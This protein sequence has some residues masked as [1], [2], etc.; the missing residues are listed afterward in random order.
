MKQKKLGEGIQI[1][2]EL[3]IPSI[4]LVLCSF[5]KTIS[6]SLMDTGSI[7]FYLSKFGITGIEY[8]IAL[9]GLALVLIYPIELALKNKSPASLSF[10]VITISLLSLI[11]SITCKFYPEHSFFSK[12]FVIWRECCRMTAEAAFMVIS[13][14][15]GLFSKKINTLI[16]LLMINSLGYLASAFF[17]YIG[18]KINPLNWIIFSSFFMFLAGSLSLIIV[19]NGSAPFSQKLSFSKTDLKRSGIDSKQRRFFLS[20]FSTTFLLYVTIALFDFNFFESLVVITSQNSEQITILFSFLY[21]LVALSNFIILVFTLQKKLGSFPVLYALPISLIIACITGWIIYVNPHLL[22][23]NKTT[24]ILFGTSLVARAVFVLMSHIHKENIF[25]VLPWAV[26]ERSFFRSTIERKMIVEPLGLMLA[27]IFIIFSIKYGDFHFNLLTALTSSAFVLILSL[28]ILR[29]QYNKLVFLNIKNRLWRGGRM[30]ITGHRIRNLI[31]QMLCSDNANDTIYALRILEDALHPCLFQ[32]YFKSLFHPSPEVRLFALE[33]L[34]NLKCK[35]A[36]NQIKYCLKTEYDTAV[37]SAALKA[38]CVLGSPSD[39]IE[40]IKYI[41]DPSLCEGALT[42]LLAVGLEGSFAAIDKVSSMVNYGDSTAQ[43]QAA[44]ILGESGKLAFFQPLSKLLNSS[45]LNVCYQA[46]MAAG[47]LKSPELLPDIINIFRYPQLREEGLST[48]L[49]YQNLALPTFKQIW[50]SPDYPHQFKSMLAK[51][52]HKINTPEC[53]DLL[54]SEINHDD[55]RIRFNILKSLVLM[56]YKAIGNKNISFARL[57]LYDEIEWATNLLSSIDQLNRNSDEKSRNSIQILISA[58]KSEIEYSKERIM[59]LLAILEPTPDILHLLSHYNSSNEYRKVEQIHIVDKILS[60][61]L[62]KIC[63]PFFTEDSLEAKLNQLRPHF[64][65]PI[66]SIKEHVQHFVS[67][68]KTSDW[69]LA[70]AMYTLADIGT[71]TD[72]DI[73]IPKL[74]AADPMIRETAV[75]VIGKLLTTDEA[76]RILSPLL[77]DVAPFV[78]RTTRFVIDGVNKSFF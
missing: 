18:A 38:I 78:Q 57:S 76:T 7:V 6:I 49:K 23:V 17:I 60:G 45:D 3:L 35:Y 37:S 27:G 51:I 77:E 28:A 52:A 13:F 11:L 8:V 73:L 43:Q 1:S 65:P 70:C 64:Y 63:L 19:K 2:A 9:T 20:F 47:K 61:E 22:E 67:S 53:K 66:L 32:E 56:N 40:I 21:C 68:L 34:E 42:G 29:Q 48:L 46:L 39:R 50:Q 69:T 62:R 4:L 24:L 59:L 71:K 58:L 15:F 33:R 25:L 44:H 26:S 30:I 74:S 72:V 41:D 12:F 36:I 5:F 55:K 31:N 75:Y 10:F 16:C 14:R 54:F